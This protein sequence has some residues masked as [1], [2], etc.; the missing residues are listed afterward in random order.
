MRRREVIALIG[1][2]TAW[3]FA[4]RAQQA[5][6]WRVGFLHPGQ[7]E[8]ANT[9]LGAFREG[10]GPPGA[11]DDAEVDTLAR[12]ADENFD[13]LPAMAAELVGLRAQAICAVSPPA[14]RAAR[15]AALS[16]AIIA[17]D[18]ESD[19]VA[20]GWTASLARPGGNV[21][22]IFLDFPDFTAKCL[23]LLLEASPGR[24]KAAVLWHPAVGT[25]QLQAAQSAGAALNVALEVLEV[26][27]VA[28]FR[29]RFPSHRPSRQRSR[30]DALVSALAWPQAFELDSAF[31]DEAGGTPTF[32]PTRGAIMGGQ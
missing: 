29:A 16:A 24:A 3:P 9:R 12:I 17:V 4:A 23:Q 7:S 5:R 6:K 31:R 32:T 30:S 14:V 21:T 10:L 18:L 27:R 1:G 2:A 28:D 20:N 26:R 11:R 15:E 25:L 22:G 19:P 8:T 13:L